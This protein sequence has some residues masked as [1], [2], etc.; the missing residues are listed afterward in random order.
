MCSTDAGISLSRG[1]IHAK[2]ARNYFAMANQVRRTLHCKEI[3]PEMGQWPIKQF[4]NGADRSEADKAIQS[5]RDAGER[6]LPL[7]LSPT[8]LISPNVSPTTLTLTITF[9]GGCE[10]RARLLT[11]T[12]EN[13]TDCRIDRCVCRV[14]RGSYRVGGPVSG[15]WVVE[16]DS[17]YCES[18]CA[19]HMCTMP[20]YILPQ[21]T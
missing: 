9:A 18:A 13:R 5:T 14:D 7:T 10:G 4:H 17:R 12:L 1:V 6:T 16:C 20:S 21:F 15:G 8:A 11:P 19:V 3:A 2:D